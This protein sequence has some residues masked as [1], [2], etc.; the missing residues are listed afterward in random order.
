[1]KKGLQSENT[2]FYDWQKQEEQ[3]MRHMSTK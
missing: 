1:M 2:Q 3:K